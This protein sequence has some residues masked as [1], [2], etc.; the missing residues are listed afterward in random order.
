MPIVPIIVTQHAEMACH[1]WGIRGYAAFAPNYTLPEFAHVEERLEAHLDGLRISGEEGWM[2][3]RE[4]VRWNLAGDVFAATIMALG[5]PQAAERRMAE[6]LQ[7]VTEKPHLAEGVS[8]ALAW[9]PWSETKPW[10]QRFP[11]DASP[12]LQQAGLSAMCSHR[13]FEG[14][15]V[16]HALASDNSALRA[17]ALKCIGELGRIELASKRLE[18]FLD[19]PK[20]DERIAAAWTLARM[21]RN[22]KAVAALQEIAI[23]PE[24]EHA[25]ESARMAARCLA[26]DAGVAWQRQLAQNPATLRQACI[27]AGALGDPALMPWLFEQMPKPEVS[28]VA[29]EAFSMMTG[30]DLAYDDLECDAP[31]NFEGGP[32]D[33]PEDENVVLDADEDLPWP[34]R[35]LIENWWSQNQGHF[36]AG[37]RYLCGGAMTPEN[38]QAAL[39]NGTQRQRAAAALELAI[40]EPVAPLFNVA[41]C[42]K[43][44][45]TALGLAAK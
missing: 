1:L 38:L 16:E 42:A 40:R 43:R 15:A 23:T 4:E 7:C 17:C 37:T 8:S 33:D 9:L 14:K 13:Q 3:C 41:D 36:A 19:A 30:V 22:P 34:A 21:H 39:R 32:N 12:V 5:E 28:R 27:A 24:A 20:A 6:I 25:A 18:S 45:S 11:A 44:Q 26:P 29:G 10:V 31:A 2:F 35:P